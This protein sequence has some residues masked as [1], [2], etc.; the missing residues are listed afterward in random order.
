MFGFL[1]TH[2][3]IP[4]VLQRYFPGGLLGED[5]DGHPVWYD[6]FNYDFRGKDA[7]CHSLVMSRCLPHNYIILI[8]LYFSTKPDDIMKLWI[9]RVEMLAQ[10]CE[11]TSSQAS[12]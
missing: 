4:Q 7:L 12:P 8:G 5:R 10:L 2:P 6:N 9:Y 11:E 3:V 1:F